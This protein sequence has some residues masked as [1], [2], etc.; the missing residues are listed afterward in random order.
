MEHIHSLRLEDEENALWKHCLVEHGGEKAEL[1][2]TV[3]GVHKNPLVRQVNEA[4]RITLS[5]AHCIMNSKSEWHQLPLVWIILMSNLQEDQGTGSG[6]SSR[7]GWKGGGGQSGGKNPHLFS[8][9]SS[10]TYELTIL[11]TILHRNVCFGV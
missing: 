5:K 11:N 10:F 7:K 3:V 6:I 1:A 4:V 9:V 8:A 2:M